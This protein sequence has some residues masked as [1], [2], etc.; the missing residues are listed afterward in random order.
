MD[1]LHEQRCDIYSVVQKGLPDSRA[2]RVVCS[3]LRLVLER[4]SGGEVDVLGAISQLEHDVDRRMRR[5]AESAHIARVAKVRES[6]GTQFARSSTPAKYRGWLQEQAW[7]YAHRMPGLVPEAEEQL[8]RLSEGRE[9]F[10]GAGDAR[11]EHVAASRGRFTTQCGTMGIGRYAAWLSDNRSDLIDMFPELIPEIDSQLARMAAGEE[12]FDGAAEIRA[13]TV[14]R[15]RAQ[16]R[17]LLRE[18]GP[19]WFR[20]YIEHPQNR[21]FFGN[22]FPEL[23]EDALRDLHAAEAEL[24]DFDEDEEEEESSDTAGGPAEMGCHLQHGGGRA[25]PHKSASDRVPEAA[26]GAEE[27][28]GRRAT[29]EMEDADLSAEDATV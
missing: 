23:L 4:E 14:A 3:T 5:N 13:Q 1:I 18:K 17:E 27:C 8:H 20:M 12:P 16:L 25:V 21:R 9:P 28:A 7:L 26:S 22:N 10:E 11:R 15:E 6:W 24:T 29:Q 19:A 2:A